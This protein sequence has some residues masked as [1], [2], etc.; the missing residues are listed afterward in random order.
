VDESAT[1]DDVMDILRPTLN[2]GVKA[3]EDEEG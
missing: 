3:E 1:L 2:G